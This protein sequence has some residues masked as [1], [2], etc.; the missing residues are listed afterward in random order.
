MSR[1]GINKPQAGCSS[2]TLCLVIAI[3][4]WS[5]EKM[6]KAP[7]ILYGDGFALAL[8]QL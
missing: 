3:K 8:F 5:H 4:V 1:A 7:Y 2:D 6:K